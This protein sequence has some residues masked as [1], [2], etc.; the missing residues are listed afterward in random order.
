MPA[1]GCD[2][3]PDAVTEAR[4]QSTG[5]D[6]GVIDLLGV[7]AYGELSAFDRIADVDP[8]AHADSVY[9]FEVFISE[10]PLAGNRGVQ[11]LV[12]LCERRTE[13]VADGL[14]NETAIALDFSAKKSVV[15][16]DR[17]S[18]R[19]VVLFPTARRPFDV[20]EEK[21]DCP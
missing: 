17:V 19:V 1:T 20:C 7:L 12:R 6:A 15:T 14:E 11:R 2:G 21:R 16:R 18:H 4:E 5:T 8:H 10:A 3:Y 13:C 9:R